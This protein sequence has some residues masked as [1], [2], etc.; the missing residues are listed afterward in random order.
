MDVTLIYFS[1]TGNTRRIAEAMGEVFRGA[2]HATRLLS[3]KKASPQDA[4]TG[5]LLGIGTPCFSSQAPTPIKAFLQ[6]LPA[7]DNRHAFVFATSGGAPGRVLFDMTRLLQHKGADVVGGFLARGELH[8]PAPCLQG[9]FPDRPDADDLAHARRFA[10]AVIEHVSDGRTGAVPGSRPD[11]FK[12]RGRFY[13]LVA[14]IST[15][16]FL[17]LTLPEPRPDPARCNQCQWCVYE[18]PVHN[19]SLQPNPVLGDHCIRCYRCLTGCPQKAFN[20]DWRLG[21]LAILT[22]YNTTFEHWFGDAKPG[23]RVY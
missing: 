18:C 4:A 17:R 16:R 11:T 22:F 6:N 3:L 10:T 2:G 5:D 13:G 7:L 12:P 15:D 20:A 8:H 21:N 9:R 14:A 23:E 19:I 1:Q